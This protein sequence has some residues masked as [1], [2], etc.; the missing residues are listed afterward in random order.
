MNTYTVYHIKS[1]SLKKEYVRK[2]DA[3]RYANI[4]NKK[5]P[6]E[7]AWSDRH[8]YEKNVVHLVTRKNIMTGQ[9]FTEASNTPHFMSP[10]FETYWSM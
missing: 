4:L 5:K 9:L 2:A 3:V 10:A 8:H 7:Y 1:T 6:G